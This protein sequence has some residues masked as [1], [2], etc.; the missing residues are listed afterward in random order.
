MPARAR[1][2]PSA[3]ACELATLSV[4]CRA[5]R[6][7]SAMAESSRG[8]LVI[9]S[10]CLSGS[11]RRTNRFHQ[12]YMSAMKRAMSPAAGEVAGGEA[13][14]APLVLQFVE[15]I[16]AIGAIAVELGECQNL[17]LKGSNEHAVFVDLRAR[18]DLDEAERQLAGVIAP[19]TAMPS[20]SR[21][22]RMTT[23]R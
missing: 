16:F 1:S 2:H 12:L 9:A 20:F 10:R 18:P 14:P 22:R 17:L 11:A 5:W 15:G 19:G 6:L 13:C 3:L 8:R 7:R 23:W 4:V 21:R